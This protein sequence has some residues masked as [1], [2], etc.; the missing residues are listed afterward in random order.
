MNM[1]FVGV[2]TILLLATHLLACGKGKSSSKKPSPQ[3]SRY[4]IH[5]NPEELIA[6]SSLN[7]RTFLRLDVLD[8][9]QNFEL[10]GYASFS[11]RSP[12]KEF[13]DWKEVEK[14]NSTELSEEED[15]TKEEPITWRFDKILDNSYQLHQTSGSR[16]D[17]LRFKVR[18]GGLELDSMNGFPVTVKHYSLKNDKKAFSFLF[19]V[20]DPEYGLTLS[21]VT[22]TARSQEPKEP[23]RIGDFSFLFSNFA[24]K[25]AEAISIDATGPLNELTKGT[26]RQSLSAW[27][28]KSTDAATHPVGL[29]FSENFPPF[30]DLNH[31]GI[32]IVPSFR[33]ESGE[34][35]VVKGLNLSAVDTSTWSLV[36]SDIFIFAASADQPYNGAS[37]RTIVH[38]LGHFLGLGHEF[39]KRE[40][41]ASLYSSVMA[42]L[43]AS[44]DVTERDREAIRA[45]Y[46]KDLG[47]S[48]TP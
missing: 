25:W 29:T 37:D 2:Y 39:A 15:L 30:S 1:R 3:V 32:T 24:I 22:F 35:F 4:F 23:Q 44:D 28:T 48:V 45:L 46:G 20:N 40:S 38:E 41:G 26:I 33:A 13:K 8:E 27:F 7:M 19:T 10:S 34:R 43:H 6:G 9:F 47:P 12:R 17:S 31:H 5:G 18:D 36:D 14:E 21:S 42:Y 11:Q 16:R